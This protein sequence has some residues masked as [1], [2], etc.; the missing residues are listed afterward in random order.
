MLSCLL[1]E[2]YCVISPDP[3]SVLRQ[4]VW[5]RK[6]PEPMVDGH[7][8][9]DPLGSLP[10]FALPTMTLLKNCLQCFCCYSKKIPRGL[11]GVHKFKR[12]QQRKGPLW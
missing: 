4:Y 11:C 8:F 10:P 1:I 9:L 6:R 12:E 5:L 3:G 7:S 2:T